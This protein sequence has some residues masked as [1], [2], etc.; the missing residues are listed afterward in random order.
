MEI[1]LLLFLAPLWLMLAGEVLQSS[2]FY[3]WFYKPELAT[4][5]SFA[6]PLAAHDSL[7][8]VTLLAAGQEE[9]TKERLAT[10]TSPRLLQI[11]MALWSGA[12]TFF[13][14]LGSALFLLYWLS[15]ARPRDLGLTVRRLRT[16]LLAGLV[17]TLVL[18]PGVLGLNLLVNQLYQLAGA[19]VQEHPFAQLGQSHLRL[20][21]WA[22]LVVAATIFAPVWEELLFRGILQPWFATRQRVDLSAWLD[23][24]LV[25]RILQW[26]FATP[27]WGSHLALLAAFGLAL[28]SHIDLLVKADGLRALL[29]AS[30][31]ALCVLALLP[32]YAWIC[33]RSKSPVGPA[34][35]ATAVLF[36][37][38]HS[39]VWPSPI[40]LTFLALGLGWLAYRTQSLVGP[41][42]VH[43][44]FNGTACVLLVVQQVWPGK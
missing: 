33:R 16:N 5:G 4:L 28:L 17:G 34:L 20:V 11:R 43:A 41:M 37:W 7:S 21:E 36:G 13:L 18:T 8:A 24:S 27:C 32:V 26:F 40:A 19:G 9:W 6:T 1:A 14:E 39:R 35:F 30:V 38:V 3:R 31:P 23:E 25:R 15:G 42:V 12:L 10:V 44:L 22:L 2:G 29:L